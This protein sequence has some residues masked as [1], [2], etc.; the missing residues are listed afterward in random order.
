MQI[1]WLPAPRNGQQLR[2]FVYQVRARILPFLHVFYVQSY[3][4]AIVSRMHNTPS[5]LEVK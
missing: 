5:V 4:V 3:C 1:S 2:V